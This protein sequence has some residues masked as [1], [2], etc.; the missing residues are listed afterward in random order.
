MAATRIVPAAAPLL[1]LSKAK[2]PRSDWPSTLSSTFNAW[3]LVTKSVVANSIS[4]GAALLFGISMVSSTTVPELFTRTEAVPAMV[5]PSIPSRR[6]VPVATSAKV[7]F[8]NLIRPTRA[9]D[10]RTPVAS[11]LRSP[12]S[13]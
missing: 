9:S 10:R 2:L 4:T 3:K 11:G 12:F 1:T 6:I 8:A 7:P 5:T 13:R